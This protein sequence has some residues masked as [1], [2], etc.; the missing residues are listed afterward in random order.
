MVRHVFSS[1]MALSNTSR[2]SKN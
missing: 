1:N 2:P